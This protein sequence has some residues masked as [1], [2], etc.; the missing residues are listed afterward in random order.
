VYRLIYALHGGPAEDVEDLAAETFERAWR[1]RKRFHGDEDAATGW[2]ITIARNLVIDVQRK[3]QRREPPSAIDDVEIQTPAELAVERH[4]L[5]NEQQTA[6]LAALQTLP[7]Q[8][9]EMVI[10]H[11]V[12]GWQVKRIA[13]HYDMLENTASVKIRRALER[14]R[15]QL[16]NSTEGEQ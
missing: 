4:I 9:R 11:Y 2:L 14:L 3:Q 6:L 16:L 1:G 8:E 13:A 12:L 15:C 5:R 7:V 10:L